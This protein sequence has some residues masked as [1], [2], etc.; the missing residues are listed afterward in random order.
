[1][2]VHHTRRD[3]T[4]QYLADSPPLVPP[5]VATTLAALRPFDVRTLSVLRRQIRSF[6]VRGRFLVH[7]EDASREARTLPGRSSY[8]RPG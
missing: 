6:R 3:F 8:G 5:A 2:T 4:Y 7:L 1:V